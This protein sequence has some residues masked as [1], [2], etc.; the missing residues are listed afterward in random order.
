M[1]PSSSVLSSKIAKTVELVGGG[2]VLEVATV[3]EADKKPQPY[4]VRQSPR[5]MRFGGHAA[6]HG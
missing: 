5:D 3:E 6:Q 4:T 1:R 2:D